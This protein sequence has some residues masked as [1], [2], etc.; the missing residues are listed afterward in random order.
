M[1]F[2][3]GGTGIVGA[4][5]IDALLAQ[6]RD[7]RA[8]LRK[9]S[10]TSIVRRILEHY[11]PDGAERFKRIEWVEGDLFDPD[12]LR[13]AMHGVEHVYHCAALVSFEVSPKPMAQSASRARSRRS[14][15]TARPAISPR[16]CSMASAASRAICSSIARAF[17][18]C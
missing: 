10:V 15:S 8:L 18:A 17:A 3:T 1:D 6:G 14:N 2:V 16:C 11:H 12:V 9:G 4:H 13:E 7:V 5:V